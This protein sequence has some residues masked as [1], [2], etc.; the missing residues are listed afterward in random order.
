[1]RFGTGIGLG[2]VAVLLVADVAIGMRTIGLLT[3]DPAT[4][5]G[6]GW[7][8]PVFESTDPATSTPPDLATE[9]IP[10]APTPVP[11]PENA[12]GPTS[13]M[14]VP[15]PAEA[16]GAQAPVAVPET[17][18]VEDPGAENSLSLGEA[19]MLLLQAQ[20]AG[21]PASAG[22]VVVFAGCFGDTGRPHWGYFNNG[23]FGGPVDEAGV[24]VPLGGICLNPSQPDPYSSL[25]H[26]LGHRYFWDNGLWDKT[27]A[28]YGSRETAAECF[29][30]IF[31]ATVFGSGGC[32]DAFAQ[33][34]R[35]EFAW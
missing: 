3:A 26:E 34:M 13:T 1:V 4:G 12:I 33:R 8:A 31:G 2:L 14:S 7:V 25:I 30:R 16:T 20:Q 19:D 29:A 18:T 10:V 9:S 24:I 21:V 32:S 22:A 28:S 17:A 23:A 11:V 15:P 27:A 35:V 5:S 6:S